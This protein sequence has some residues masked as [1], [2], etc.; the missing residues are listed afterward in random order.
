MQDIMVKLF[1][2]LKYIFCV[3]IGFLLQSL[4]IQYLIKI[5]AL[6]LLVLFWK[7]YIC[8]FEEKYVLIVLAFFLHLFPQHA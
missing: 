8:V 4:H 6:A 7:L 3:H 1:W 2:K 5:I